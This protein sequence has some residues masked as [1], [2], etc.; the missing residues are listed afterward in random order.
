MR[1]RGKIK[2]TTDNAQRMVELRVETG[3]FAVFVVRSRKGLS[4]WRASR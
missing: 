3:S 4:T 2:A 1:L